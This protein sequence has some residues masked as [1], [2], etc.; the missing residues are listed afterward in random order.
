MKSLD[1][2]H[3]WNQWKLDFNHLARFL[4]IRVLWSYSVVFMFVQDCVRDAGSGLKL[5]LAILISNLEIS[6]HFWPAQNIWSLIFCA[7]I[8]FDL[9]LIPLHFTVLW[10]VKVVTI[11]PHLPQPFSSKLFSDYFFSQI[12]LK[13][14]WFVAKKSC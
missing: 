10:W 3:K 11:L 8:R 5:F 6:S 9:L 14:G 7:N 2:L 4:H 13:L 1:Y 12:V